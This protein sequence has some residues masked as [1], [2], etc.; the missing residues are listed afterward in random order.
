MPRQ[1]KSRLLLLVTTL[2]VMAVPGAALAQNAIITGVIADSEGSP[3]P[4]AT[5][6]IPSLNLGA[7][8]DVDGRFNIRVPERQTDG[9]TVQIT[10]RF[11]GSPT[12]RRVFS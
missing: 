12:R 4:G 10:A 3:L 8:A 1:M 11:V 2:L 9:R 6:V 7:A 5:V